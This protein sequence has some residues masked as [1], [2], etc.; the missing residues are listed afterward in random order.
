MQLLI[1]FHMKIVKLKGVLG[2]PNPIIDKG[3]QHLIAI[4]IGSCVIS[5]ML[6][7]VMIPSKIK[8]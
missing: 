1:K 2:S 6:N 7:F 5:F 8:Y 3:I 4:K